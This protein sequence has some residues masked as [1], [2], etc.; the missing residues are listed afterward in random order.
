MGVYGPEILFPSFP[1]A[2]AKLH[3]HI[4]V[5]FPFGEQPKTSLSV[6]LYGGEATLA[7]FELDEAKLSAMGVP[8]PDPDI[9]ADERMLAF[10]LAFT[11]TPFQV[12]GSMRLRLRAYLDDEE[13][14]GNGLKVRL[15][16][17]EERPG[18]GFSPLDETNTPSS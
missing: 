4:T 7:E 1:A 10:A 18:L 15:A 16:T 11:L 13:I 3:V 5:Q 8:E 14:K 17:N 12:S 2:L 9:P 6:I